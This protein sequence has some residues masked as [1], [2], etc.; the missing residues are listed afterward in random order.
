MHLTNEVWEHGV[1]RG[2]A[3]LA[4]KIV[5]VPTLIFM[6]D[7]GEEEEDAPDLGLMISE[8]G[9]PATMSAGDRVANAHEISLHSDG[10]FHRYLWTTAWET[11]HGCSRRHYVGPVAD[12]DVS[13]EDLREQIVFNLWEQEYPLET[14]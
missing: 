10:T 12:D 13:L 9:L 1:V 14:R 3:R 8:T 2:V 4:R 11:V 5:E 7:D 6:G